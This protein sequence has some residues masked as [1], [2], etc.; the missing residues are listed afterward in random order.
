M[1]GI[2][3]VLT[4]ASGWYIIDY[5][6][7]QLHTHYEV[8]QLLDEVYQIHA[9]SLARYEN[10][11]T[12]ESYLIKTGETIIDSGCFKDLVSEHLICEITYSID[13]YLAL[14]S[15]LSPYIALEEQQRN[16]LFVGLREKL[17]RNCGQTIELVYISAF[18]IAQKL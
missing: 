17:E 3:N 12:Q 9:P 18:H 4:D 10:K 11:E 16:S 5:S 15:T 13:D 14:L 1:E 7:C 6:G 2:Q 8:Y